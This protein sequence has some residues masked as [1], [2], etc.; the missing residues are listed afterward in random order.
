MIRDKVE[1]HNKQVIILGTSRAQLGIDPELLS[2]Q[3]GGVD[4]VNLAIDGVSPWDVLSDLSKTKYKNKIIVLATTVDWLMP[5]SNS[6]GEKW[7]S[8][9]YSSIYGDSYFGTILNTKLKA[10]V[11]NNFAIMSSQLELRKILFTP[12]KQV[13]PLYFRMY[14]N[15]FKPA[16]YLN[17]PKSRLQSLLE[18][19]VNLAKEKYEYYQSDE[20]KTQHDFEQLLEKLKRANLRINN[21]AN[22]L[23]ML[24]MPTSGEHWKYDELSFPHQEYWARFSSDLD[25]NTIHF[26]DDKIMSSLDCPDGSHLDKKDVRRFTNQ[27]SILIKDMLPS[28]LI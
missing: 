13:K 7:L 14:P 20:I 18:T 3:L 10:F 26:K 1:N 4:V 11:Q 16:D 12:F 2:N 8:Y 28:H 6:N 15:R 25:I 27:V 19:R 9:Y 24:R 22:R 21:N 23:I 5:G 17:L